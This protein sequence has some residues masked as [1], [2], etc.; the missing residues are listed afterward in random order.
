MDEDSEIS[1]EENAIN[2]SFSPDIINVLRDFVSD[3]QGLSYDESVILDAVERSGGL[4]AYQFAPP[5]SSSTERF[6]N[7][8]RTDQILETG[9]LGCHR[10]LMDWEALSDG[11]APAL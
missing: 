2:P 5:T 7:W 3:V 11:K 10:L 6:F 4:H 1:A 8:E 9:S